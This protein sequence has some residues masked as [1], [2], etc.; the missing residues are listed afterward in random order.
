[1]NKDDRTKNK[2]LK[3]MTFES[4]VS[5]HRNLY[6]DPSKIA[7]G[8]PFNGCGIFIE[9]QMDAFVLISEKENHLDSPSKG[10]IL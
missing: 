8:M 2:D 9:H 6:S 7:K 10:N 4:S 3:E 5:L 1:M